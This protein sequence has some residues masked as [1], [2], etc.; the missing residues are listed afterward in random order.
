MKD[1]PKKIDLLS[2]IKKLTDEDKG[3]RDKWVEESVEWEKKGVYRAIAGCLNPLPEGGLHLDLGC[4]VGPLL[5]HLKKENPTVTMVGVERNTH[6]LAAAMILT[7]QFG[8][9]PSV[10]H[11]ET[12]IPSTSGL[13]VRTEYAPIREDEIKVTESSTP[14]GVFIRSRALQ[15][16]YVPT[17]D[18]GFVNDDKDIIHY[19]VDDIRSLK[20]LRHLLRDRS[21]DSGSLTFPGGSGRVAYEM[22]YRPPN[23]E[24]VMDREGKDRIFKTVVQSIS[25]GYRFF[26]EKLKEGG[27]L[28]ITE[29]YLKIPKAE[30][31]L[32]LTVAARMGEAVFRCFNPPEKF[33]TGNTSITRSSV[34]AMEWKHNLGEDHFK[35]DD[36]TETGVVLMKFVRNERKLEEG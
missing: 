7:T 23:T 12:I 35:I 3:Y 16:Y 18:Q 6:V 10:Y 11:G 24:K 17:F 31:T 29:R 33:V 1:K 25:A 8:F 21:I 27:S 30:E 9:R 36:Q 19:V 4:G 13:T 34:K 2:A 28:I 15:P 26:A 14:Q 20:I 5:V 32:L 22:P